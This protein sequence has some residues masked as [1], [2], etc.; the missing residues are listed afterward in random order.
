LVL[1]STNAEGTRFS[2]KEHAAS[3]ELTSLSMLAH[4]GRAM[5]GVLHAD[6]ARGSRIL[7]VEL[8][9]PVAR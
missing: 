4:G 2:V 6:A 1:A 7:L 8:P 3:D 9:V 5:V